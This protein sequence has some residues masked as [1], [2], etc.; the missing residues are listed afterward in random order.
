MSEDQFKELLFPSN[1]IDGWA[2]ADPDGKVTDDDGKTPWGVGATE[3]EAWHNFAHPS[4]NIEASKKDGWHAVRRKL[5][6][7]K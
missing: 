4:L 1:V 3:E 5:R 7:K 6:V 2:I